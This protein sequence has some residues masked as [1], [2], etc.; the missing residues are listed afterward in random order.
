VLGLLHTVPRWITGRK[1]IKSI[2]MLHF[3]QRALKSEYLILFL[4][5]IYFAIMAPWVDGFASTRNLGNIFIYMLPLLVVATG[6]TLVLITAGIDLSV[7]SIIAL[8]SVVATLVVNGD[9]GP[10]AGSILA[11]PVGILIMLAVG[12]AI[13]FLNGLMIAMFRMP[14]FIVTLTT[15]MFFSGFAIW[16]TQSKSIYNLPG[17]ILLLGK[18]VWL[19]GSVTL[20]VALSGHL[21]LTRTLFGRWLYALGHNPKA[22]LIAGVPVHRVII[23]TYVACGLC[24]GL[25]AVLITG[26][27]ETGSPVHW[28]NNL[29]DII[30]AT[31]IGGTSLYGGRGKVIWTVFGVLFLTL[32]DNSL[33]L[34][35]LS[36]F[37]IMIVKGGVILFAALLDSLRN[38]LLTAR[39]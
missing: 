21:L 17:G 31:V 14:A 1:P 23:M 18:N 9:T 12:S 10:L 7:T 38:R 35:D 24:A 16:L 22:A 13:G 26:R 11:T 3:L 4:C 36:Y 8:A 34:M 33:N 25:A 37:A 2:H 5:G 19:A 30:G 29:L 15:M 20:L 28:R 39:S 6:Q 27:L 32:I